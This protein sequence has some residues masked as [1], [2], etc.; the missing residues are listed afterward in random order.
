[1]LPN[2]DSDVSRP[3]VLIESWKL[4][5]DGAG[6]DLHVLLTDRADDVAGRQLARCQPIGVEP[7]AHAVFARAEHLDRANAADPRQLV[8]HLQVR[9][10]R[11]VEH[12]VALVRR[13][14]VDDHDEVGRRLL[15]R[16]A[17]ALHV[18]RQPRL[19]LRHA[20]LHLHLRVVEIGAEREGDRQG[21]RAVRRRLREHVEHAVDAVHLLLERRGDGL[22]DYL[23]VGAGERRAHDDGRGHDGGVFTDRQTHEREQPADD[24]Q[25]R[26]DDRE[27]RTRDEE[28]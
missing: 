11:Q 22:G 12:V 13:D 27:D 1:M 19:R 3:R 5:S 6:G 18:L 25:Q 14:E 9:V 15:G 16:H 28:R 4:A 24:D 7:H 10:V 17:D 23:R 21:Q 20:V 2:S 8:L 26:Q